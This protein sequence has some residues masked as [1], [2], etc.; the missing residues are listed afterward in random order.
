VIQTLVSIPLR[1]FAAPLH[2]TAPRCA[3][4][5]KIQI[6]PQGFNKVEFKSP[7]GLIAKAERTGKKISISIGND[8][9]LGEIKPIETKKKGILH[10]ITKHFGPSECTIESAESK[11]TYSIKHEAAFSGTNYDIECTS[12]NGRIW[13]YRKNEL[14]DAYIL[15]DKNERILELG[16]DQVNPPYGGGIIIGESPY[17]YG[18]SNFDPHM[19][20]NEDIVIFMSMFEICFYPFRKSTT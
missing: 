8:T 5:M 15:K 10:C 11:R 7:T 13:G 18:E 19:E 6:Y 20:E 12:P 3:E 17:Y 4:E 1:R 14:S 9:L 2:D 16:G